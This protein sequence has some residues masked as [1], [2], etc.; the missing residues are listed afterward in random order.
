M[1]ELRSDPVVSCK[2]LS[3]TGERK[4]EKSALVQMNENK[5]GFLGTIKCIDPRDDHDEGF[6]AT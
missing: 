5:R 1:A 3:R 4:I 2:A 6:S